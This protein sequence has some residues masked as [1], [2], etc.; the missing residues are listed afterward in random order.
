MSS[1]IKVNYNE[2]ERAADAIDSYI[3]KQ[4]KN[5]SLASQEVQSMNA[6]WKGEDFQSFLLKWNKLDDSDSTS[7]AFMKSLESY[8][9]VLRHSASQYKDAQAKAIQKANSL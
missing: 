6:A 2:L 7:Y 9:K 1:Y 8:T 3:S 5:M 4:K